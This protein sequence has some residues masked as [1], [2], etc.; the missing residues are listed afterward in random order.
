[1][2]ANEVLLLT[3]VAIAIV[4]VFAG[5]GLGLMTCL[6]GVGKGM[7]FEQAWGSYGLIASICIAIIFFVIG[8]F[9]ALV[10]GINEMMNDV[11][12]RDRNRQ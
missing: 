9:F 2:H 11:V 5:T 4:A 7:S 10:L 6:I 8:I 3:V 12:K 1:M